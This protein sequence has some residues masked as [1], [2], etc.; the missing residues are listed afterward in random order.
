MYYTNEN[1]RLVKRLQEILDPEPQAPEPT[2]EEILNK[3][4]KGGIQIV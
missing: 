1:K 4:M 2:Q 3:L